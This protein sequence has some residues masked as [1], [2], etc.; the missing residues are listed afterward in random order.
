MTLSSS[1][2]I[3]PSIYCD[4]LVTDGASGILLIERSVRPFGWA[5][6]G[7]LVDAGETPYQAAVRETFEETGLEVN[8]H[9]LLHSYPF[10]RADGVCT[11][12]SHVFV[13]KASGS[14][15]SGTD[16]RD[17]IWVPFQRLPAEL[18]SEHAKILED[19]Q[20]YCKRGLRPGAARALVDHRAVE[21]GLEALQA[22]A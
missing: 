7:G 11:G 16:S 5:L 10:I 1:T 6:P 13:G 8:I 3:S 2:H 17:A 22:A 9:T 4:I 19:Y 18:L 20:A 15:R 21:S 12:I 14:P